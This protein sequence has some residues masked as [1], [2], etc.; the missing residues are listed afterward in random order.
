VQ[1]PRSDSKRKMPKHVVQGRHCSTCHLLV[2][3][4][5]SKAWPYKWQPL[6]SPFS[7]PTPSL[8]CSGSPWCAAV[9]PSLSSLLP[10]QQRGSLP[11]AMEPSNLQQTHLTFRN[12]KEE[13]DSPVHDVW[14]QGQG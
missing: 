7:S 12:S 3:S 14:V 6:P 4:D 9:E 11:M 8:L 13:E 2:Q 5:M 10:W 1:Q